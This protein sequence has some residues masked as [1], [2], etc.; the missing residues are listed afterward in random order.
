M[1]HAAVWNED[2]HHS[3]LIVTRGGVTE[4]GVT[5][6]ELIPEDGIEEKVQEVLQVLWHDLDGTLN[7][8]PAKPASE[9]YSMK[10]TTTNS[11]PRTYPAPSSVMSGP[12]TA[13]TRSKGV[14]DLPK[15]SKRE[16]GITST[17][18][19][20]SMMPNQQ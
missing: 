5:G 1:E 19:N 8:N 18:S 16:Q 9:D 2:P 7:L 3:V 14:F 13:A 12:P 10:T 4:P 20:A 6:G 11:I 15:L 17:G